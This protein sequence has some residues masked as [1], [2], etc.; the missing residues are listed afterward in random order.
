MRIA[1]LQDYLCIKSILL[2]IASV[3]CFWSIAFLT[4]NM[5]PAHSSQYF[6]GN[7]M[8]VATYPVLMS[9]QSEQMKVL[10]AKQFWYMGS[11]LCLF[12]CYQ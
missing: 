11:Y 6:C 9:S 10:E 7:D 12:L 8:N 1:K 5:T 4:L 3:A 2:D